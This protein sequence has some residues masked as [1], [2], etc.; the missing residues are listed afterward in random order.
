M[1]TKLGCINAN[2]SVNQIKFEP[3]IKSSGLVTVFWI[4]VILVMSLLKML[5]PY[6]LEAPIMSLGW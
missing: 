2:E 5:N 3:G 4:T 1:H 6:W